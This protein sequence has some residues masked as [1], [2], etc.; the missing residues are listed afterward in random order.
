[1]AGWARCKGHTVPW[2]EGSEV[3]EKANNPTSTVKRA[4]PLHAA[5]RLSQNREQALETQQRRPH[6]PLGPGAL[7]S[8]A[9]WALN[10]CSF[11]A[12]GLHSLLAA[13][14]YLGNLAGGPGAGF[15]PHWRMTAHSKV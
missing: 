8:A 6:P 13:C 14:R 4:S 11:R 7:I 15:C 3:I 9:P 10:P 2:G 5:R 1:M 12:E